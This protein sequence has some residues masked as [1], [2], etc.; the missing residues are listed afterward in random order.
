MYPKD[1]PADLNGILDEWDNPNIMDQRARRLIIFAPD[2]EPWN[3]MGEKMSQCEPAFT[4][5]CTG[6]YI[7]QFLY[8][9]LIMRVCEANDEDLIH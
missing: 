9:T 8:D 1:T 5:A 2:D 6:H 7:S 3:E 4:N